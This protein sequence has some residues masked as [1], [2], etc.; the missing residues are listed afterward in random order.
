[1]AIPE[2]LTQEVAATH[3]RS[4]LKP[5]INLRNESSVPAC[6]PGMTSNASDRPAILGG[7]PAFRAGP[8]EWP[9]LATSVRKML[10]SLADTGDWGRYHG[11]HVPELCRRL[12]EFHQV[13]QALVCS[14]GTAAVELALRGV[15]VQP[16]DEVIMA[17]YD[18]KANFQNIVALGAVPVLVDLDAVTWQLNPA[19][20][21]A[22]ITGKTRAI[23]ISHLHGGVVQAPIVRQIADSHGLAV[24]EDACQNPGAMIFGRL[25]GTWGD[26]GVLSFGGSKVLTAGRG[27]AVLT[28]RSDI[29]ERIKRYV[30]RGNDAYPLSE[31]QAAVTIPQLGE[32]D[33]AN[34]QRRA[35]VHRLSLQITAN[36]CL[37]LLQAPTDEIAPGYYKVGFQY[38]SS[39]IGGLPRETFVDAMR[40]E[41][42]AMDAGFRGNHL[43]HAS[44][45]FRAAG[46]LVE[47]SRAD[48]QMITLHHPV[49]LEG[50]Q[51]ID[52]IAATLRKIER[53]APEIAA[54]SN[55]MT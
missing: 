5:S 9:G 45:R 22:A 40:A 13:E 50:D 43:I 31:L 47:S 3:S 42:V 46:H 39:R 48:A 18:F 27:G 2:G 37:A 51:A 52:A 32:L 44:R 33:A 54:N 24:I 6:L 26:V 11:P 7:P 19:F 14:S 30:L 21:T 16:G 29:A 23:L 35:A 25:A 55:R 38:R 12:T 20:L 49:L 8:P 15:G 4:D 17:A 1:M 28:S 10:Q 41:G 36:S 34:Q 53:Y